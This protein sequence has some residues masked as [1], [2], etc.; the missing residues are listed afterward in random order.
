M[1][2]LLSNIFRVI[3]ITSKCL[4]WLNR[5]NICC[6]NFN[7]ALKEKIQLPMGLYNDLV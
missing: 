3:K 6:L 2:I 5:M 1:L 7:F 4:L